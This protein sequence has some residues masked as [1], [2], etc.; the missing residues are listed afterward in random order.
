MSTVVIALLTIG[1]LA[2][3]W[4]QSGVA[5]PHTPRRSRAV[6]GC[7]TRP[8]WIHACGP[9]YQASTGNFAPATG[10]KA[11]YGLIL[12]FRSSR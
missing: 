1:I 12:R 8:F 11:A 5:L 2:E 10:R 4:R 3:P 7:K 9:R 6:L